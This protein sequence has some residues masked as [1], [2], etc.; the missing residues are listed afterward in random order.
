MRKCIIF[1]D[2][3]DFKPNLTPK[4]ILQLGSFGGTYF[5]DIY[6]SITNKKYTK[7]W[8]ELPKDW[9]ENLD[10]NRKV[11]SQK[12]NKSVNKYNIK[13]GT[14]L[15]MWESKGWINEIDPYGWFQWYCRFY[16]GR[17]T[18]DDIRQIERWKNYAG[19]KGRF[20]KNLIRK[21][22]L[23]NTNYDDFSISPAIRQGLL[24]WAYEITELDMKE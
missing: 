11:C 6:S 15:E 9:L 3:P 18:S 16:Q 5:R 12:Y 4:E 8:E 19:E 20:K 1:D 7:T 22:K 21:I 24:H 23:A 13:C 10:I 14:S 17:R 2:Y